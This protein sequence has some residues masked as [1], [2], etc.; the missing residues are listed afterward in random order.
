MRLR[1]WWLEYAPLIGPAQLAGLMSAA[2]ILTWRQ[3]ASSCSVDESTLWW[4]D[5]NQRLLLPV[6]NPW[7]DTDSPLYKHSQPLD[8]GVIS[9]V[10]QSQQVVAENDS[11]HSDTHDPALD[12]LLGVHTSAL[13]AAPFYLFGDCV[14]VLSA[15]QL[16][17]HEGNFSPR[18][19]RQLQAQADDLAAQLE[20]ALINSAGPPDE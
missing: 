11:P 14:G 3:W 13:A 18:M 15:V 8:R 10:W 5:V 20:Q 1:S 4:A 12:R 16:N 19:G 17:R 6:V 9:Y 2:A 7:H